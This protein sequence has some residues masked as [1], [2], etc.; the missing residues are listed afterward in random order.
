M[1]K[2]TRFFLSAVTIMCFLANTQFAYAENDSEIYNNYY[3][4]INNTETSDDDIVI[5]NE[6]PAT[7]STEPSPTPTPEPEPTP[8]EP[9]IEIETVQNTYCT[10]SFDTNGGTDKFNNITVLSNNKIGNL[11]KPSERKGY[12]FKGWFYNDTEITSDSIVSSNMT[13]T[14]KWEDNGSTKYTVVQEIQ[15][16]DGSFEQYKTFT[17]TGHIN[18]TLD[19]EAPKIK[20]FKTPE[21]QSVTIKEDE[22][23]IITFQYERKSYKIELD[24]KEGVTSKQKNFV[25]KFEEP[26]DLAIYLNDDY[27]NLTIEGGVDKKSFKMPAKD[28]KLTVSAKPTEYKIIYH[29]KGIN[30]KSLPQT[31]NLKTIPLK[32][33]KPKITSKLWTFHGWKYDGKS[34]TEITD[35]SHADIILQADMTFHYIYVIIPLCIIGCLTI[36]IGI[37]IY[38]KKKGKN[39]EIMDNNAG[40][41]IS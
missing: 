31:Y 22:S 32:L 13:L 18:E 5:N 25:Y 8:T 37:Y 33:K 27:S 23:S 4:Y 11:P 24:V 41:G 35:T 26:V 30:T 16:L 6:T 21:K 34:I 20:G 38:K 7:P 40:K 2:H 14:A 12:D 9:P 17:Q 1:K 39:N 3:N 29:G 28:L 19:V 36:I 15:K 10:V